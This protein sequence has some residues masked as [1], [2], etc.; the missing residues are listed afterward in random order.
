M[1]KLRRSFRSSFRRK[2][3][4]SEVPSGSNRQWPADEAA[5][6]TNTCSFEVK[7]LGNVEVEIF[8]LN[9]LMSPMLQVYYNIV[10]IYDLSSDEIKLKYNG[11]SGIRIQRYASL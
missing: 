7:Y 5:V 4:T 2:D 11:C 6:K 1:D 8:V 9:S 3:D 10:T